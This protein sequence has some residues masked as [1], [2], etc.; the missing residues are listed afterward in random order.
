MAT[1]TIPTHSRIPTMIFAFR[2]ICK[3]HRTKI[4]KIPKRRSVTAEAAEYAI[5]I[6]CT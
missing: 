4:G 5:A 6:A 1:Y 3:F 2:F